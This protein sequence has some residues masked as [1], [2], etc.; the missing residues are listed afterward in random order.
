MMSTG[1]IKHQVML[2]IAVEDLVREIE[3]RDEEIA[4]LQ[5]RVSELEDRTELAKAA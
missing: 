1:E 4:R 5:E 2:S 3:L